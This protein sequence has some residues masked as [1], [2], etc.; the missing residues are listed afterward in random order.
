M[1]SVKSIN[2]TLVTI[3]ANTDQICGPTTCIKTDHSYTLIQD[4][5]NTN[6]IYW[7]LPH[8]YFVPTIGDNSTA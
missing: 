7:Q 3:F 1:D 6:T 5:F 8:D 4:N 2:H